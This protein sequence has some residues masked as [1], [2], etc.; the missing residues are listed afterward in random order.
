MPAGNPVISPGAT[1]V[2]NLNIPFPLAAPNLPEPPEDVLEAQLRIELPKGYF[3]TTNG[4]IFAEKDGAEMVLVPTGEYVMGDDAGGQSE[5]PAHLVQL[6]AHLIDRHEVTNGQ[7]A[8]FVAATGHVTETERDLAAG[9]SYW[10]EG[11]DVSWRHARGQAS[12]SSE[13]ALHPVVWVSW[14]DAMAYCKWAGRRLPTEAEF[15]RVLRGGLRQRRY[16]WGDSENP[17]DQFANY[18]DGS[19][20]S[21]ASDEP[22]GDGF[23][24]TSPVGSFADNGLG[25]F[26]ISGNVWEWCSDLHSLWYYRDSPRENPTGPSVTTKAPKHGVLRSVRGGSYFE[27]TFLLKCA[28]RFATP[29]SGRRVSLGFRCAVS[30]P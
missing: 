9:I 8:A 29:Q 3:R 5:Q 20:I 30:L 4:R 22:W 11:A 16:P 17:P 15:E 19:P 14:N 21:K 25:V 24:T 28:E 13:R 7:F 26:D 23:E 18:K 6:S 27:T 2:A 12:S 10:E 1:T